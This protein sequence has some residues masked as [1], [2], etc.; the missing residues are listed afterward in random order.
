[1]KKINA[2]FFFVIF[3]FLCIEAQNITISGQVFDQSNQTVIGASVLVLQ[4]QDSAMVKGVISDINGD[5]RLEMSQR[6]KFIIRIS[7]IGYQEIYLVK[8]LTNKSISLG[9]IVLKEKA[10]ELSKVQVEGELI[11]VI[12]KGDTTQISAGAYKTNPD[13]NAEDLV[14]KMPGITMQD[15]KVQAHGETVQ[16][17]TVD[18]QEYFGDDASATLKNLPAEVVD[19][20]EIFDKKSEQSEATGFDDGSTT[21]TINIVTKTQFRDG[22]FGKVFAGYG[23]EDKWRGGLNLNFF[24]G[25]R[26]FSI[27]ANSNNVNEQNFSSEDLLG[28]MSSGS[29]SSGKKGGGR[30]GAGGPSND[31]GNFLVDQK[32]GITTT[33]SFGV[34]YANQWNNVNFSASYFL[35]YSDNNAVNDLYRQY[36]TSQNDGYTYSENQENNST[37][38]NHRL[39]FKI[40]WK[41]DS[42]NSI[43]FQPK[44]SLQQNDANSQLEGR[45]NLLTILQSLTNNSYKSNLNGINLSAPLQYRHSFAKKGRTFSVNINPGYNQNNGESYLDSWTMYYADTLSSDLL[46]Q[47]A[48]RDVQ[49]LTLTSNIAYTEPINAKSQLM[50]SYKNNYNKSN[51][52]KE[53]SNFSSADNAYTQLDTILS[54]KYNSQYLSHSAGIDYRY[55]QGKWNL[56]TGLAYQ[57]AQLDGEQVF[58]I[59]Y[60]IN[61]TFVSILPSAQFQYKYSKKKNLRINYRSSNKAP[62]VSQLQNVIDNTNPLQLSIG[63]PNLKQNWQN[64]FSLRYSTSNTEKSRSFM[65]LLSATLTQNYIV[66][67]TTIA[68]QDSLIAPGIILAKGSQFTRPVNMDGYYSLRSF[69]IYSFPVAKLKSNLNLNLGG[70]Y[71][72]S[73]GMINDQINFANSYNVGFG[74]AFSSNISESFDFLISSNTTYNNISN[75]LQAKTNSEYYNQSSKLKIQ[76]MPWKWMVLQTDINH[77]YNSGLSADYNKNYFLWNA[78]VGCKFLKDNKGELRLS[79]FDILK[80]NNSITRNTTET[81]YED[82]QTNV[83][84]QYLL[85]TFTYNIKYYKGSKPAEN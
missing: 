52:D 85:L 60:T 42:L 70:T 28:V 67:H 44:I 64:S 51:S 14:T 66:N 22:V 37:N 73:P 47:M 54:N 15:G 43:K 10:T 58:P 81:Y 84:Q 32:S 49:G 75:T 3:P 62:S 72:R 63:N 5:F 17:V 16:K 80:Q 13:A 24:K 77:Q 31:A 69:N 21:K 76:A 11:P 78:A 7:F 39:N 34:N 83:L 25:K 18:G 45:N 71:T 1:M 30:Q 55:Q 41:I 27:L 40:D 8:E 19:K 20:I 68:M 53:I 26:R 6:G 9:K 57:Y 82:V 29:G 4:P 46:D 59:D 38:L 48:N 56:T 36:I 33:H 74:L 50:F 12:Q 79:V 35:N 23:Y 61:K 2:L 65:T